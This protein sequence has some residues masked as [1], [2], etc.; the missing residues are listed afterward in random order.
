MADTSILFT[1]RERRRD[2]APPRMPAAACAAA[3]PW[4]TV[5]R[6]RA[7]MEQNLRIPGPTPI[8]P[9]VAEALA[10]P[11]INHR[12]PE[13]A[14][15]LGRVTEGL[16]HFFQTT[17]SM[18]GFPSSGSGAMEAAIVNCFSPGDEVLSVSC[19]AFGNRLARI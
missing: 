15:I 13:F 16:Q 2:A 11:M 4:R 8:P 6:G 9:R 18:L 5:L 3:A 17:Q 10:R 1:R 19:G 7:R 14:A 12:G